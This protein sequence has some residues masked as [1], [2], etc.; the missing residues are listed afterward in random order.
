MMIEKIDI[1]KE[2]GVG[3]HE[4]L[5]KNAVEALTDKLNEVIGSVNVIGVTINKAADDIE[6]ATGLIKSNKYDMPS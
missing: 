2:A 5:L 4:V 1:V 6:Y 3:N